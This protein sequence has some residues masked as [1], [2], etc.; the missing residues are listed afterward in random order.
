MKVVFDLEVEEYLSQL[1]DIL[2]DKEYFG[3]K[4][5]AYQYVDALI[6]DI[7]YGIRNKSKKPAPTYFNRY[8]KNMSYAIFKK[9]DN[10]QWYVFFNRDDDIYYIRYIGNNHTC[11][12]YL[13]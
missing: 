11:A 6:D 1:V 2:Y 12:Q 4:E 7:E 13:D 9:N 8:G 3:L 5:S 10:T